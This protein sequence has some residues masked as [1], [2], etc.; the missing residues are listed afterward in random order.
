MSNQEKNIARILRAPNH[1]D[2]LKLPK[3]YADL[4]DQPIWDCSDDQVRPARRAARPPS[5]LAEAPLPC[6]A[7]ESS[8]P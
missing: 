2:M 3:P 5:P 6:C 7:G 1:F 8:V 4:L